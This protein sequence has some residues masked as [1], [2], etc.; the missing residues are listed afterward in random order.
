MRHGRGVCLLGGEEVLV[1]VEGEM[2]ICEGR[3]GQRREV[4]NGGVKEHGYAAYVNRIG[5]R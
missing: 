3:G 1:P 5:V 4:G 2:V